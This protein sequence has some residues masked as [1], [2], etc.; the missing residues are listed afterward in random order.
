MDSLVIGKHLTE[1]ERFAK[2][3]G[4][5]FCPFDVFILTQPTYSFTKQAQVFCR[6]FQL[7]YFY[8][9]AMKHLGL[10]VSVCLQNKKKGPRAASYDAARLY[11]TLSLDF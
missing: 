11:L 1:V 6:S 9:S 8:A 7:S 10:G 3:D 2:L 4:F 5:A